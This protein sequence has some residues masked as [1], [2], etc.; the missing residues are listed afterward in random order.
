[1]TDDAELATRLRELHRP[2]EP[3]ILPNAWDA[4]SAR[5]VVQAGFAAVATTSWG[6]A[7]SLGYRDGEAAPPT[8]MIA[9]A[10]RI[11]HA[12]DVPVTVDAEAGYGLGAEELVQ[13]LVGAGAHG[14]NVEDSDHRGGGLADAEAQAARIAALRRA[15]DISGVPLVLNA[16]IDAFHDVRDEKIQLQRVPDALERARRYLDAGADCV[17]PILAGPAAAEAMC[18]GL[19]GANV[20]LMLFAGDPQVGERIRWAAQLGVA[21]VSFGSSLWR[22]QQQ[23][24][25]A[26]LEGITNGARPIPQP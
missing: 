21:R 14:C 23:A 17:Y 4:A 18:A 13:R 22:V 5:L 25:G 19:P 11:A 1:V 26:A 2:G 6:V 8:E 7:E 3:L 9:A 15:A 20:N 16:R 12:V 10:A 24:I